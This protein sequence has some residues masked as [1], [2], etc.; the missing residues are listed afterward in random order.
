MSEPKIEDSSAVGLRGHRMMDPQRSEGRRL[1]ILHSA[2]RV[3]A[4]SGYYATTVDDIARAMGVSKG[5]IYYYFRSKDEICAE[6][7]SNAI[8]GALDRLNSVVAEPSA[9]GAEVLRRAIRV[10]VEYNLDDTQEG[11]YAMLVIHDVKAL[12]P[13]SFA[14]IRGLQHQYRQAF[15][16]IVRRG[17]EDGSLATRDVGVTTKTILTTINFVTEWYQPGGRMSPEQV[18]GHITEQLMEGVLPRP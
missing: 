12:S 5:V 14:L 16:A 9:F 1:E 7:L 8:E 11:Y 6:V 18:A 3:F 15:A 10:H 17:M 4:R 2:A 13:Q